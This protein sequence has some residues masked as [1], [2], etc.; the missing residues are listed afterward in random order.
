MRKI[1]RIREV[2]SMAKI[3]EILPNRLKQG[4]FAQLG[5][6]LRYLENKVIWKYMIKF[7]QNV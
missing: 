1:G 7:E 5:M 4:R 6:C 2:F 3:I